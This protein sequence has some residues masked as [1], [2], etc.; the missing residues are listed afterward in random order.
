MSFLVELLDPSGQRIGPPRHIL[1]VATPFLDHYL[2][3]GWKSGSPPIIILIPIPGEDNSLYGD[4]PLDY[5]TDAI[6]YLQIRVVRGGRTI[7]YHPHSVVEVLAYGLRKWQSEMSNPPTAV[8]YRITG[9][10][11]DRLVQQATPMPQ[12]VT[13][14]TPYAP[15]EQPGF[16][17]R[18]IPP[19]PPEPSA[20]AAFGA[21]P[22]TPGW[23][24]APYHTDFV[25]ILVDEPLRR[26]LLTHR[27]FS[28]EVEEGGFLV[29]RIYTDADQPETYIA[30]VKDAVPAEQVGASFLHFTFTGDSF[31]RIKQ[32]LARG[33]EEQRLLGWYHTHLFP[34]TDPIGLS[35][36]DLR[37]HFTT[38]R[39]PWQIA[40]LINLDGADRVLRFYVRQ[41]STMALCH[42]QAID[43][44]HQP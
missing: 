41:G 28:D 29:G 38:F 13:E 7:Y 16:R 20:L 24:D 39:I 22:P 30:H 19:P 33:H 35:S 27:S 9:P 34:A 12:G 8:G 2:G 10:D 4:S 37:L 18:P 44:G 14:V 36:I 5:H 6:G 43:G 31:E 17:I 21:Q 40:G 32:R 42:D 23:T 15:G 25:K 3:N 11:I 26:E 1:D